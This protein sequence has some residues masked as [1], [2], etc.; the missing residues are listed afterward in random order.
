MPTIKDYL[1]T[2]H[3]SL[4]PREVLQKP[5][6]VLLGVTALAEEQ[7]KNLQ[8]YTVF[9]LALSGIFS[10]A[11]KLV[12]SSL[13]ATNTFTKYGAVPADIVDSSV[14]GTNVASLMLEDIDVLAGVGFNIGPMLA[15]A[16][17]VKTIRDLAFWPPYLAAQAIYNS[18]FNP[19]RE[20]EFNREAPADL[21][22]KSG[23]YPTERVQ[24]EVLLFDEFVGGLGAALRALG[25]DGALDISQLLS[26]EEGYQRPAIGG[27]L[28]FTQSWYTK[29]L[30]LGSLIHGVALAPGEST[31]IAVIDWS[32]KTRTSSTENITESELLDSDLSRSR[33]IN[34]ITSAVAKETQR[35][36]SA[37]HSSATAT[38]IG[39]A[40]GSAGFRSPFDPSSFGG[41][42]AGVET[43]GTST[44]FSTGITD[45]TSWSTSSGERDIDA[46][47][48]Q[49]IVDSTHQA[50][51][52]ARNRR[53]SIVR[54]VSQQESESIST[55]T[56]TN[57]NHMHA[58]TV[59]YYEVVQLYQTVVELS[60]ADRCLFVPMKLIDFHDPAIRSRFRAVLGGFGLIPEVRA[61]SLMG[62][63][64]VAL[65]A[66]SR[67]SSWSERDLRDMARVLQR[68]VG[69]ADSPYLTFPVG[70]ADH[71]EFGFDEDAPIAQAI[72][73]FAS[74]DTGVFNIADR[75]GVQNAGS[76]RF[77]SNTGD[78][79][80]VTKQGHDFSDI[81]RI[82][83]V[84]KTDEDYAGPLSITMSFSTP[85]IET[86]LDTSWGV[87]MHVTIMVPKEPTRFSIFELAETVGDED[88]AR[89]LT[90]NRLYYSQAIWRALDPTNI[91]ILVSG[92]TWTI[93]GQAKPLVEL[94]DPTPVAIVA[95]YLVLRM[96]GDSAVEHD[97]WLKKKKIV[98]GSRREDTVPVPSGGVFAEAVLGRFNSAEKLDITRFWNWQDSPIPIQAPDIA[99]VQA[100]SR[101]EPDQTVPGQLSAPVLNIVNPPALPDPQG[102][103]AI[104]AAIQNG[105]MFRD[106]S[107][108]A[109]T[110][111]LAQAGLAGAQQGAT[112]AAAQ[113]GKNAAVAAELGA[114]VAEVAGKIVAA[115]LTKGGSLAGG[116]GGG[117]ANSSSSEKGA[118]INQGRDMDQRGL[119]S[120]TPIGTSIG[121]S[122]G[123]TGSGSGGNG[124]GDNGSNSGGSASIPT[125]PGNEGAAFDAAM[126]G[127]GGFLS[128]VKRMVTGELMTADPMGDLNATKAQ[129]ALAGK[130]IRTDSSKLGACSQRYLDAMRGNIE[131]SNLLGAGVLAGAI[132]VWIPK[133]IE[134]LIIGPA[135]AAHGIEDVVEAAASIPTILK[136]TLRK[137]AQLA[138]LTCQNLTSEEQNFWSNVDQLLI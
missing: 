51:H 111:G 25:T 53:A 121:S 42:A 1:K 28:T 125:D 26:N 55:R 83:F 45:A 48:S 124:L 7:L 17:D 68:S 14:A 2:G 108:L 54:E 24:Y 109:A 128:D 46:T 137:Q 112:D 90:A 93:D 113:A 80:D 120:Q 65:S 99:P 58:L 97:T 32:R 8:I 35:G 57:Y 88:L 127:G 100:G 126:G 16:L 122:A 84:K 118:M 70:F 19:E 18:I 78:A 6:S 96:S 50:S 39:T 98:V 91:G 38:Q 73:T 37:A 115:Y 92:Y 138:Y 102:M 11:T 135:H 27:V 129:L 23:E 29:G 59:E 81:R 123:T 95:N 66:P 110:I 132:I 12:Q 9:D 136:G 4:E 133:D 85:E 86:L 34:E 21:V 56:L 117:L 15:Q 105:N 33:A 74:G 101:G 103:G 72:V 131:A 79:F 89:H 116:G 43:S 30:S 87:T 77:F 71:F 20:P 76:S 60:K 119:P 62:P 104:L 22:P 130:I 134:D 13:D 67:A 94:V 82:E 107:G 40:T 63:D 5:P 61:L 64:Q 75:E 41:T 47:L 44:G 49:K 106:M 3:I 52:S 31:K 114:K 69:Q 10:N 36:E